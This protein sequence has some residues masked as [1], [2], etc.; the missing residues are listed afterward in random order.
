[1]NKFISI[2]IIAFLALYSCEESQ[3]D[4]TIYNYILDTDWSK[5][6]IETLNRDDTISLFAEFSLKE[7]SIQS[8]IINVP[9]NVNFNA[10]IDDKLIAKKHYGNIYNYNSKDATENQ[11]PITPYNIPYSF[12]INASQITSE[13]IRFEIFKTVPTIGSK[14]LGIKLLYTT[15]KKVK[16]KKHVD[17]NNQAKTFFSE[18]KLPIIRINTNEN[19]S[20][21]NKVIAD[22][23]VIDNAGGINNLKDTATIKGKAKIKI[24]GSSS[25]SLPKQSYLFKTYDDSLSKNKVSLL[26]LPEESE[27]V[28]YAPFIDYSLMR[29]VLG[30]KL[31]REIGNYSPRTKYFHLVINNDYRGIYVLV[32]R[33]KR[34]KNR[35]N[36]AKLNKNTTNKDSITGGYIIK[37][38]KG[39]GEVWKSPYMSKI[40]SGFGKWFIYVYPKTKNL[41]QAQREYIKKYVTSFETALLQGGNWEDYIDINSFIDYM[42]MME[43]NKNVD[44]YRLSTF[45]SKDRGGKLKADPLWDLNL[46]FGLTSYY[47]GYKTTGFMYKDKA[48]PFW[49]GYF[50]KNPKFKAAFKNRWKELR[51]TKLSDQAINQAIDEE[52]NLLQIDI[53][54]NTEKWLSYRESSNW[55]KEDQ[56]NFEESINYLKNWIKERNKYLDSVI[57]QL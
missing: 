35:V 7:K 36:I 56:R 20:D 45:Y 18:S 16:E 49:W 50:M 51:K 33:I 40:D 54:Y 10:Y 30:Y 46:T 27:W 29:N 26:G 21:E 48:T 34:G 15:N 47:D 4:N 17:L 41:N 38:D 2:I 42:I 9:S 19:L 31:H 13:K 24:R 1:L 43:V 6:N 37:L 3:N 57:P 5:I 23:F 8:L 39:K 28:L 12:R 55:R 52:V 11:I 53:H 25:K 14:D 32:E 22:F 44:G